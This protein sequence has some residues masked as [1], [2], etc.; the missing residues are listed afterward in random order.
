MTCVEA[1][2]CD[3]STPYGDNVSYSCVERCPGPKDY[4]LDVDAGYIDKWRWIFDLANMMDTDGK[5][6]DPIGEGLICVKK[7]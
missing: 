4:S 7:C 1:K 3:P 2:D 6:L 5:L